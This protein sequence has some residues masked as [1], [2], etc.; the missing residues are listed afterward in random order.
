MLSRPQ[1]EAF[2]APV[3]HWSSL[4]R[5][6]RKRLL[7][8]VPN[9]FAKGDGLSNRV[10]VLLVYPGVRRSKIH[11]EDLFT[12]LDGV[13]Q[14]N[15]IRTYAPQRRPSVVLDVSLSLDSL[16]RGGWKHSVF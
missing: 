7:L 16:Q 9:V 13:I 3:S 8:K 15:G 1:P 14:L 11:V 4:R 12:L 5:R 6:Q 10:F 2:L